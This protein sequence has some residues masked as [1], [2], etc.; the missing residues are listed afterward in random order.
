MYKRQVYWNSH[1]FNLTSGDHEMNGRVNLFYA[2][3]REHQWIQGTDSSHVYV[4]H[5]QPPYTVESYCEDHVLPQGARV[6]S[7]SSH[8]H[9]RGK[10]F[11]VET[12]DG[13]QI[14]ESLT[15]SD[16]VDQEYDPPLAFDAPDPGAR[17]LRYCATYNNGV[18][19]DGS[20]DTSTVT[21]AS[22]MPDRAKCNPV[23]CT[24]GKVGGACSGANDD[25]TCDSAPGTGDGECD[26]CPITAGVTTENEMFILTVNYYEQND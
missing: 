2:P 5:G 25:A 13:S 4:A 7:I 12:P 26:A 21:R 11:W 6:L 24:A 16:P 10:R 15:Y 20:P 18:K 22:R 23:A 17:T 8:T 1:A 9:K 19:D 14:Y 3:D